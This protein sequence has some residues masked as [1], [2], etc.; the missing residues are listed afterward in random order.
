[1]VVAIATIIKDFLPKTTFFPKVLYIKIDFNVVMAKLFRIEPT[2]RTIKLDVKNKKI[3]SL[4]VRNAR[5]PLNRIAKR[6]QLSRDAV[7]YRIRRLQQQGVIV[8][9]TPIIDYKKLG[10]YTFHLFLLVSEESEEKRNELISYLTGHRNVVRVLEFNDRWDF[11]VALVARSIEDFNDFLRQ[12][13]EKFSGVILEEDKLT[14][15]ERYSS[16]YLPDIFYEE[17]KPKQKAAVEIDEKD[18][19]I[20]KSLAADAKKPY[21]DIGTELGID[22]DTVHNR[23]RKMLEGG[24]IKNFT[25]VVDISLL[26]YSFY[27]FISTMRTLN[28]S[29]E[30]KLQDIV[31]TNKNVLEILKTLGDYDVLTYVAVENPFMLH[32]AIKEIKHRFSHTIKNYLTLV[33]YREHVFKPVP[34]AVFEPGALKYT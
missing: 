26:N 29:D 30:V 11:E 2:E 28:S 32:K 4:L 19:A 16:S 33:A 3:L 14:V 23:V 15:L 22:A 6:V 34:E 9:Y 24:V 12:L 20:L 13:D 27:V 25:A 17:E 18:L 31:A 7:A 8:G 10:F 21:Y 5:T 1:M